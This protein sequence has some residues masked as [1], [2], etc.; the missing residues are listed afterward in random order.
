MKR[1]VLIIL[2]AV[3]LAAG[4]G[5]R[6][7]RSTEPAAKA[8]NMRNFPTVK[9][10][11][12]YSENKDRQRFLA[13]HF[14]D[15]F[16]SEREG[17]LCDSFTV[18]GVPTPVL[19]EAFSGYVAALQSIDIATAKKDVGVLFDKVE[20][21]QNAD[22]ESNVF[23]VFELLMD[24]YLYDP[25]SPFRSEDLY[26][27]YVEK[28]SKSR[29]VN[30]DMAPA[31][32][33]DARLCALNPI[34]SPA[35]DFRFTDSNGVTRRLH[36]VQAL[37]TLVF[38]SNPGCSACEEIVA[39]IK[40]IRDIDR[41]IFSGRLAIINVYIDDDL[42]AWRQ[43]L[44]E[45]PKNWYNGYDTDGVIRRD[46]IYNIRGIPSL[47]VLDKDKRVVMKDA[48]AENVLRFLDSIRAER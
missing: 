6:S 19:E 12:V 33:N 26:Q 42:K 40:S 2:A 31:L 11:D 18:Y 10:P 13:E 37:H 47:Y 29:F 34:G 3:A 43:H 7:G 22:L 9:T 15:R 25:N 45:F 24:R 21:A 27:P 44:P 32:A 17:M 30:P 20:S 46:L 39:G 28:L 8:A 23:E 48:P 38:F 16:F 41:K 5:P 14:W 35:A 4:C 36:D 1:S